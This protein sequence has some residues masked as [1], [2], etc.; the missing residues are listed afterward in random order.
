[1][2]AGLPGVGLGGVF[3]L[4]LIMWMVLRAFGRQGRADEAR[5]SRWAFICKMVTVAIIMVGVLLAQSVL[6]HAA[7]KTAVAYIPEMANLS[8]FPWGSFLLLITAMPLILLS[9][10]MATVH[11]LRLALSYS[12]ARTPGVDL[13]NATRSP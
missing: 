8:A 13:A 10:L 3:Y 4:L 6:I 7:F 12:E 9:L 5:A 2:S 1:M 11:I